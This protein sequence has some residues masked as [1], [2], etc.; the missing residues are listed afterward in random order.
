MVHLC[1]VCGVVYG[2]VVVE[3]RAPVYCFST[4]LTVQLD[5]LAA[6][7]CTVSALNMTACL[8]VLILLLLLLLLCCV[9]RSLFVVVSELLKF[10]LVN[11][12]SD[13]ISVVFG[14]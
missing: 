13:E 7:D 12:L 5:S 10:T 14:D 3:P 2:A 9:T 4:M 6:R 11:F 8:A 1:I